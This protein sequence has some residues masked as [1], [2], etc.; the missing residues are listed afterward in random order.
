MN[1]VKTWNDGEGIMTPAERDQFPHTGLRVQK[2]SQGWGR[3]KPNSIFHTV[4]TNVTPTD[5]RTGRFLHWHENRPITILE[6]RRAQGFLDH[7]VL[8][9]TPAAQYELVGNSVAR[10]IALALGLQFREAWLGSLYDDKAPMSSADA[11]L[12]AL[13]MDEWAALEVKTERN[14]NDWDDDGDS[15]FVGN[16]PSAEEHMRDDVGYLETPPTSVSGSEAKDSLPT[17]SRKRPL[18]QLL[19]VELH[20]SKVRK[21]ENDGISMQVADGGLADTVPNDS[22]VMNSSAPALGVEREQSNIVYGGGDSDLAAKRSPAGPMTNGNL[23]LTSI[24]DL[25]VAA[26]AE[27]TAGVGTTAVQSSASLLI[28]FTEV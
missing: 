2:M 19:V 13:F 27:S 26:S 11:G 21:V 7:E 5:V 9:G 16:T 23:A 1:F 10:P 18:S 3:V 6:V 17:A 20:A 22:L 14:E 12:A 25:T 24:V 28:D 8:V 15:L 4:T